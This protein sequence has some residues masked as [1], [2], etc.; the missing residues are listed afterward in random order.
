VWHSTAVPAGH[1][2]G[3]LL[4]VHRPDAIRTAVTSQGFRHPTDIGGPAQRPA[5][6]RPRVWPL[7][8][9]S[10]KS[11]S[12]FASGLLLRP[13]KPKGTEFSQIERFDR[14]P[15]TCWSA[16]GASQQPL[17]PQRPGWGAKTVKILISSFFQGISPPLEP[18]QNP[19]QT[20]LRLRMARL[21]C[22]REAISNILQR[23]GSDVDAST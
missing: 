13:A 15:A 4:K 21:R 1:K 11:S 8:G 5:S 7:P 12:A 16:L 18:A 14:S 23:A 17:V 3:P 19:A 2:N 10:D 6:S 20:R 9:T 22:R